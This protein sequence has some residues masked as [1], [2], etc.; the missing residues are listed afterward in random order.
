MTFKHFSCWSL[1]ILLFQGCINSLQCNPTR[2]SLENVLASV[3]NCK[4]ALA[5][6]SGL[7]AISTVIQL[8]KNGDHVIVGRDQFVGTN[9]QCLEVITRQGIQVDTVDLSNAKELEGAIKQNTR[10]SF[11]FCSLVFSK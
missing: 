3:E 2:E 10:V 7:C 4:Y 6:P 9:K 1:L 8:L 5:T 11:F